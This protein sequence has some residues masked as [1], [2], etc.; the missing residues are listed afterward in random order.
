M[1]SS[2]EARVAR[3][4]LYPVKS[5]DGQEVESADVLANGAL[6]HDRAY[7]LFDSSGTVVNA[8][9]HSAMQRLRSRADLERGLLTFDEKVFDLH[10][11]RRTL[12]D[13]LAAALGFAV[14]LVEDR[15]G[16]FPDDAL[17]A[18]PTVIG[19]ATL[20]VIAAWFGLAVADVRAR[21][22]TNIEIAGVPPF[23]EDRLFGPGEETVAFKI[24]DTRWLGTNPCLRCAVPTRDPWSGAADKTFAKRFGA[25][26]ENH[27]PAWAPRDRFNPFYRVA[28]N[29]RIGEEAGSGTIRVGD[30]VD[31]L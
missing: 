8:K 16:G 19:T 25:L 20:E 12:E 4:L 23:W 13:H 9:R 14:T 11:D 22:R 6:A 17:A 10:A 31:L 29:T 27:L 1:T 24:S 26:R 5:L 2:R 3:L 18:G 30:P 15:Q 7:A 28:V 21:L